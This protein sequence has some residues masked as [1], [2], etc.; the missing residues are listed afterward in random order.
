[1]H[2]KISGLLVKMKVEDEGIKIICS[3][4][5]MIKLS[6]H[7]VTWQSDTGF[8]QQLLSRAILHKRSHF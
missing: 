6:H 1:M 3:L 8:I 4:Q 2:E 7:N 5:N